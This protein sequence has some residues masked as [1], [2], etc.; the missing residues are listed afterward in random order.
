MPMGTKL[1]FP[2]ETYGTHIYFSNRLCYI[3]CVA[4]LLVM[5]VLLPSLLAVQRPIRPLSIASNSRLPD[6]PTSMH[7]TEASTSS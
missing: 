3:E 1:L 2:M 4:Y 7:C 6:T 5:V